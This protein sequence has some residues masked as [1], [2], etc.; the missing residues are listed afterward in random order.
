MSTDARTFHTDPKRPSIAL[1][2]GACDAH[3][4]VFGPGDRF[5]YAEGRT[6]TPVDVPKEHLF[7][8]HEHLGLER[9]VIVQASCH[10][11]DNA[12]MV[13]AL[14]A[15]N[16]RYRGVAMV[17]Q[18]VTGDEL[19]ELHLAGVRGVRFNF[20]RHLGSDA[21]LESVRRVITKIAPLGWHLVVHFDKERLVELIPMLREIPI[22]V[23]ID[24][25]GRPD[26]SLGVD[27][28]SFSALLDLV[29][30]ERFWVKVSGCERITRTGPPYADAVPF[31]QKLMR[32]IPDRVLWGTDFPHPNIRPPIP[33][34]GALVDLLSQ[35]APNEAALKALLVDNPT[36]LY[37][38]N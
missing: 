8:L 6:Y 34:D 32:A 36:Q 11:A 26:A 23:V 22:P 2:A 10:G 25:M 19:R 5:P 30:D 15:G 1:P 33:D 20:V 24:H 28:T 4:H 21:A 35:I 12:A 3:C 14:R 13:D 27:Q 31:A 9:G 16:D 17:K 7:S 18:D 38:T 37:W 29:K